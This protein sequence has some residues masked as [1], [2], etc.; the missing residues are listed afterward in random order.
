MGVASGP[1]NFSW[2]VDNYGTDKHFI[3]VILFAD[4]HLSFSSNQNVLNVTFNF[5]KLLNI[6]I[7]PDIYNS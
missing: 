5:I 3:Q 2:E 7:A 4:I 6:N 1:G